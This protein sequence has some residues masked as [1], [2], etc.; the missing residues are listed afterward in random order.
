MQVQHH[1]VADGGPDR[2]GAKQR[3][4][5][6]VSGRSSS[7]DAASARGYRA[8]AKSGPPVFQRLLQALSIAAVTVGVIALAP[9]ALGGP[10]G[11]LTGLGLASM[12]IGVLSGALEY[13][14]YGRHEPKRHLPT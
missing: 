8:T 10:V 12:A 13:H 7:K 5:V 4:T 1:D 11:N 9:A 6:V 14:R 3:Q 2:T